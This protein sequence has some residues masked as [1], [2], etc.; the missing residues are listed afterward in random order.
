M[1]VVS[2]I[3]DPLLNGLAQAGVLGLIVAV[4]FWRDFKKDDKLEKL[5]ASL[6]FL[7]R[8]IVLEVLTRPH[9]AKRAEDEAKEIHAS[10]TNGK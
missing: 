6:N 7:T 5:T 3:P 4:L 2:Q 9:L 10:V 1:N 8:S